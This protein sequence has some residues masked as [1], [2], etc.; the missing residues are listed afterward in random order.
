MKS[1]HSKI[2]VTNLDTPVPDMSGWTVGRLVRHYKR[3]RSIRNIEGVFDE[4][5]ARGKSH[6]EINEL[7]TT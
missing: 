1:K 3:T 5:K 6:Q 2:T 4:L 7:L